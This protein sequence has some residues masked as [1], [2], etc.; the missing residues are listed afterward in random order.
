MNSD[1]IYE[2]T[3]IND[4][5]EIVKN[6]K[7]KQN[8]CE[9]WFRGI[10]NHSYDLKPSLFR[11]EKSEERIIYYLQAIKPQ[12]F[13]KKEDIESLAYLQ[14]YSAPT[15]LLDWSRN[16]L[17]SLFFAV[18]ENM[19]QD[20]KLFILNPALLNKYNSFLEKDPTCLKYRQ[21]SIELLVRTSLA[22]S[23]NHIEFTYR[24]KRKNLYD[25]IIQ[26]VDNSLNTFNG[27]I[28]ISAPYNNPRINAQSGAFTIQGGKYKAEKEKWNNLDMSPIFIDK[29]SN[30]DKFI[31]EI[32]ILQKH[33]KNIKE[34]LDY[35]SINKSILFPEFE[36]LVSDM[37]AMGNDFY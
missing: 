8:N 26:D 7:K 23:S 36:Y 34:Q 10:S 3:S 25:S 32:I 13:E 11:Q 33:K 20:G 30:K 22:F 6:L 27:C 2:I 24:M 19:N 21:D 31:T 37:K 17:V 14:H 28:A 12:F 18:S 16:I 29:D 5:I 1:Y 35:L 9:L 4:V 15:R